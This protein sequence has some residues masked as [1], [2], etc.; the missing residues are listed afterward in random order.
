MESEAGKRNSTDAYSVYSQ[1]TEMVAF[2][3]I[4]RG[5]YEYTIYGSRMRMIEA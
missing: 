2:A 5:C 4:G 3:M 1:L